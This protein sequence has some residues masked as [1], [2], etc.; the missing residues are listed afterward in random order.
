VLNEITIIGNAGKNAELKGDHAFLIMS[1]ATS[2]SYQDKSGE[3]KESTE[4]HSV[5]FSGYLFE[6][7]KEIKK[8]DQLFIKGKVRTYEREGF[9]SLQIIA[10]K[11]INFSKRNRESGTGGIEHQSS[12]ELQDYAQKYFK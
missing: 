2:E 3:W 5:K 11:L 10:F 7:A 4:W 6:K 9:K 1:V 8:G 12:S